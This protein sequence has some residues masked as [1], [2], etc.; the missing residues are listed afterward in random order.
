MEI[1]GKPISPLALHPLFRNS[2][3]GN[4]DNETVSEYCSATNTTTTTTTQITTTEKLENQR[5]ISGVAF[6]CHPNESGEHIYY[7]IK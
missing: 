2:M 3:A 5:K 7:L 6:L 1:S 4:G